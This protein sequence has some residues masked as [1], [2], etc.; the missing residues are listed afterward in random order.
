MSGKKRDIEAQERIDWILNRLK[1]GMSK[2]DLIRQIEN[3]YQISTTQARIWLHKASDSLISIDKYRRPRLRAAMI[4]IVRAQLIGLQ[5]D[6]AKVSVE[7][8]SYEVS[9]ATRERIQVQLLDADD[10][11]RERLKGELTAVR[12]LK[13][14]YYLDCI[15]QRSSLR[16]SIVKCVTEIGRLEGLYVEELPILRALSVLGNSELIPSGVAGSLIDI[17]SNLELAL[18]AIPQKVTARTVD[19]N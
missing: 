2:P 14:R 19:L 5:Q 3:R 17:L 4:E 12:P 11:E 1:V 9:R 16:I 15:S 10:R 13:P 18:D 6:I 7:I 8:Q